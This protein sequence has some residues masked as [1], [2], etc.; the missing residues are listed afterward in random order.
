MDTEGDYVMFKMNNL[1]VENVLE[2]KDLELDSRVISV[3]GQSGSG[4]STL[5]RLLNNLDEPTSGTIQFGESELS[6]IPP[7]ELRKRIVMVPQDPV[8]FDG[9]IRDNLLIGLQF[10][11]E[12]NVPD[13]RLKEVLDMFRLDKDL[14]TKV[15]E[16]SGGEQQRIALGRVLFLA[17]AEAYLLDEPSSDLDDR[18]T[19]HIMEQFIET[20]KEQ[21]KQTIM[22]THDKTV[23]KNFADSII[24][25]DPYSKQ[26]KGEDER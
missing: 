19:A 16:L 25:M 4:K 17:K 22:V 11:G 21:G 20:A 1:M 8:M 13:D 14:D 9:T 3:E 6:S 12:K 7:Q 15:S 2:I 10:S 18:T 26:I 5:L 24:N 23:S